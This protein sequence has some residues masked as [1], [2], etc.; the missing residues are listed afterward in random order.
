MFQLTVFKSIYDKQTDTSLKFQ[1]F[2]ELKEMFYTCS[3][4]PGYKPKK[5]ERFHPHASPL[6]SPA[7]YVQGTTRSNKNVTHWTRLALLDVDEYSNGFDA[8]IETFKDHKFICYSSASSTK[9]HPKFRVVLPLTRNVEQGEI[10]HFW[11]SLNKEFNSLGDEQT[12]DFSRMY[13]V[14]AQYPNA[15]N[16]IA[17]NAEKPELDVDWLLDKY[18]YARE[19]VAKTFASSLPNEV[20]ERIATYRKS[21]LSN[22]S[23]KW[24]GLGNCPFVNKEIVSKYRTLNDGR[25][26][27]MFSFLVSVASSAMKKGYPITSHEIVTLA[28]EMDWNGRWKDRPLESEADRAIAYC[29]NKSL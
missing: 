26:R 12:K 20:Q 11:F 6:I 15:Y 27:P 4:L 29:I 17:T 19:H 13:Y 3:R 5:E 21:K 16:F 24:T 25:Y 9:E 28:R 7:N 10:R 23:V 1:N 8:A 14:P 2:E 22:T 18:A